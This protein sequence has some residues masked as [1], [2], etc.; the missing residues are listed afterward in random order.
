MSRNIDIEVRE[1]QLLDAERLLCF[2]QELTK[3]D[4]ERV[5]RPQDARHITLRKEKHWIQE[6]IN[7]TNRKEMFAFI[8]IVNGKVV[9]EGEVERMPRWIE[10]HV[11]EIRIGVL[12]SYEVITPFLIEKLLVMARKNKIEIL[13]YFHLETQKRGIKVMKNAGFLGVGRI[14]GYYKRGNEYTDRLYLAK[15]LRH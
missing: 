5:E 6:R 2:F 12:P 11:A 8:G 1:V 13:V 15:D 10:R 3:E 4:R 9:A 7:K 14:K